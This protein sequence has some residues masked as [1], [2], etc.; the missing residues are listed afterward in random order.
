MFSPGD[1]QPLPSPEPI[2][3]GQEDT[4]GVS[5]RMS[6]PA[7]Q[8]AGFVVRGNWV[9]ILLLA[10]ELGDLGQ[11]SYIVDPPFP[12]QQNEMA[13]MPHIGACGEDYMKRE[14]LGI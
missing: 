5:Y 10:Y 6:G 11:V 13:L 9:Q 7:T 4:K 2:L 3:T 14:G 12:Q 8:P 1:I